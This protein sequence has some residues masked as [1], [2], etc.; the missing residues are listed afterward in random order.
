MSANTNI[1]VDETSMVGAEAV[2]DL[3]AGKFYQASRI[4]RPLD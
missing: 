3:L 1:G 2:E 4:K